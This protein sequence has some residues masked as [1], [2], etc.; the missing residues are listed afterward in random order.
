ML[1]TFLDF[2]ITNFHVLT[3]M[4]LHLD[5]YLH[6]W[7]LILGPGIYALLFV[8]VFCETGLVVAP[9]LPG[10][11]LLFAAGALAG[12]ASLRFSFLL[13]LLFV[14]GGAGDT[15]N[16]VIGRK[17]GDAVVRREKLLGLSVRHEHILRAQRFYA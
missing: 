14:A 6:K 3:E 10:D 1:D 13:A 7:I 4:F 16:Y 2:F 15:V 5:L 17:I 11:S 9:F 8:V 12:A